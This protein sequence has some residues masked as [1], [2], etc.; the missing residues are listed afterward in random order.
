M[1]GLPPFLKSAHDADHLVRTCDVHQNHDGDGANK[2]DTEAN[3]SN[4]NPVSR[5][6]HW[7]RQSARNDKGE[8][9]A[10][11]SV[12]NPKR[13]SDDA[14][15]ADLEHIA[16]MDAGLSFAG[17]AALTIGAHYESHDFTFLDMETSKVVAGP[18]VHSSQ[19]SPVE[20]AE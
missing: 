17:N 13:H 8:D 15:L 6:L 1:S 20:Y 16:T 10:K 5:I 18:L 11:G 2:P 14:G 19:L 12:H 7:L 3:R 4:H 9:H